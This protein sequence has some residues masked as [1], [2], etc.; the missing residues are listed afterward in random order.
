MRVAVFRLFHHYGDERVVESS[1]AA[2]GDSNE[3]VRDYANRA[4]QRITHEDFGFR[5][6]ASPRRRQ[7]AKEKWEKWWE[8]EKEELKALRSK[9]KTDSRRR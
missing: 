9:S 5:P 3:F 7:H 1:I 8:K 4:L 6:V 2:L